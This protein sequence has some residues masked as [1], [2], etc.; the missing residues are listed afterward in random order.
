MDSFN[1]VIAV[2]NSA[3]TGEFCIKVLWQPSLPGNLTNFCFRQRKVC[4]YEGVESENKNSNH[5]NLTYN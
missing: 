2:L 1:R 3:S 5:D 4:L